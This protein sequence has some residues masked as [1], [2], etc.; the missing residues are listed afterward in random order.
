MEEKKGIS[1]TWHRSKGM[2]QFFSL[3]RLAQKHIPFSI[4]SSL[5][6]N[7]GNKHL[8]FPSPFQATVS[9]LFLCHTC[10]SDLNVLVWES[11][12][13]G[14]SS[15]AC[16]HDPFTATST[17]NHMS[18]PVSLL[19]FLSALTPNPQFPLP[20][21]TCVFLHSM[22]MICNY[23]DY[24]FI[25]FLSPIF[26]TPWGMNKRAEILPNLCSPV[27]TSVLQKMGSSNLFI[28]E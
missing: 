18:P 17:S 28:S 21:N 7:I 13:Q 16:L 10:H 23:F 20:C 26:P 3:L 24:C 4:L 22:T 1:P 8:S 27:P 14:F 19:L 25:Y 15:D 12:K 9:P 2:R 5:L 11:L 6:L